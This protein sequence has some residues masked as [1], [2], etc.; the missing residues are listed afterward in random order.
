[1][2]ITICE[3]CGK[4]YGYELQG[5]VSPGCKERETANCPYCGHEGYSVMTSQS[6][7]SYKI[8]DEGN[9]IGR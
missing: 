6:I 3:K 7:Y 4:K 9:I 2:T 8:D 1:M 5:T